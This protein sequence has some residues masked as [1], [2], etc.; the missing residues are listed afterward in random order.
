MIGDLA[1]S[2]A[3]AAVIIFAV[4]ALSFRSLRLGVIS[5]LPNVLPLSLVGAALVIAGE[6]LQ[7]I[8]V[9]VFSICLGLGV[10]NTIHL[11]NR[12]RSEA[13]ADGDIP[14]AVRRSIRAVGWAI[15]TATLVLITGFAGIVLSRIP[16]LRMFGALSCVA[17]LASI[18]SS[19][20]LLP[21]LLM[22]YARAPKRAAAAKAAVQVPLH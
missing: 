14:A 7:I 17:L 2:L 3:S 13:E 15:V 6:S 16:S 11:V 5:V 9:I 8:T 4:M 20:V 12:F 1:A 18:G 22:L 19:L 21:A 10:D